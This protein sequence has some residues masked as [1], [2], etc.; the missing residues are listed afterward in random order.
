MPRSN[1]NILYLDIETA[2][3]LA[4]VWGVYEQNAIEVHSHWYVLSFAAKWGKMR[5]FVK[6]L[7][8]YAGYN[9]KSPEAAERKLLE[10]VHGLLTDADLVV[11]HNGA[12]FDV[13][14][15]NARFIVHGMKPPAPYKVIDTKR[16]T[17]R[18]AAF[19]SNKL[20]WLCGQLEL[21]RKREHQGF[22]LWRGCMNGDPKA[23]K[24]MK[25]YNQH[26]V[27]LLYKLHSLLSPWLRQPNGVIYDRECVN[28]VCLST[29][30][31]A[32]GMARNKTRVYQRF[33][34]MDCGTWSREV[35]SERAPRAAR[36]PL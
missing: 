23:W 6:G 21:G 11:A 30:L 9:P 25:S 24:V 15:L 33:Q 35:K 13:K 4:W 12:D 10:E 8:D 27:V 14:K 28:P 26:D 36:V 31:Q 2:P 22:P 34:C 17:K 3:D 29:R 16:D 1:I 20:D 19:S 7:P 32:R 18:V 5:P